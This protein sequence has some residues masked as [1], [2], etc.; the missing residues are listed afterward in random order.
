[1]DTDSFIVCIK[2]EDIYVDIQNDVE[3]RFDTSNYELK[4][5][6]PKGKNKNVIVLIKDEL[7]GKI[8]A[9]FFALRPKI[10]NYLTYDSDENKKAKR[11]K[12]CVIKRELKLQDYK[13]CLETTQLESKIIQL[14]KNKMV[15]VYSFRENQKNS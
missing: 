11:T 9:E 5:P 10:Y 2:T 7:G 15:D 8:M 4:R 13:H 6:L 12:K 3:I 1:M 14:E